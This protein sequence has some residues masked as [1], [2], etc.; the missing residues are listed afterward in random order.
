MPMF[1]GRTL[2]RALGTIC[3]LS[4]RM[5]CG[6]TVRC[7]LQ[8]VG[9]GTLDGW[10]ERHIDYQKWLL[11]KITFVSVRPTLSFSISSPN[12]NDIQKSFTGTYCE[13]LAK[14]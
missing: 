8:E 11:Y 2:G 10:H 1:F 6:Y 14:K 12:M 7:S 9:D 3:G 4:V 5:Y 13:Q